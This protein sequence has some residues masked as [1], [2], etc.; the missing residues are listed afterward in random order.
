MSNSPNL[1]TSGG[2]LLFD[3]QCQRMAMVC[4]HWTI[5]GRFPMVCMVGRMTIVGPQSFSF[6]VVFFVQIARVAIDLS[7]AIFLGSINPMHV[8]NMHYKPC[9]GCLYI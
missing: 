6:C 4:I 2:W 5:V 9:H 3:I 7:T 8:T 1:H